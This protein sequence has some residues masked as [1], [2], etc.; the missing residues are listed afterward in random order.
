M[1]ASASAASRSRLAS[2]LPRFVTCEIVTLAGL[3]VRN[4]ATRSADW[5]TTTT[6]RSAPCSVSATIEN[7]V[8]SKGFMRARAPLVPQ[9]YTATCGGSV[10]PISRFAVGPSTGA[11]VTGMVYSQN[12]WAMADHLLWPWFVYRPWLPRHRP[13]RIRANSFTEVRDPAYVARTALGPRICRAAKLTE[14]ASASA[15]CR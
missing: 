4:S 3:P 2:P 1:M 11:I 8:A 14:L 5:P 10:Q 7:R 12:R 9:Q 15:D 13:R 6:F